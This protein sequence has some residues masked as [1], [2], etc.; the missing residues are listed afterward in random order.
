MES[1]PEF[2]R[3]Y[4]HYSG[5]EHVLYIFRHFSYTCT[6]GGLPNVMLKPNRGMRRLAPHGDS[7]RLQAENSV[8]VA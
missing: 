7:K 6:D 2:S 5:Q 1:T 4:T 3:G 8:E